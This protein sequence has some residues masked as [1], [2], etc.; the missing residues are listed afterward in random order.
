MASWSK[1]RSLPSSR[2]T[3][4]H[5]KAQKKGGQSPPSLF[6]SFKCS[7]ASQTERGQ[8]REQVARRHCT[9]AVEVGGTIARFR[10]LA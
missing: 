1:D 4:R 9:V 7:E 6:Q 2:A 10:E 8:E 5:M 3:T